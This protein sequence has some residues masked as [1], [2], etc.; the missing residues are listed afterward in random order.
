MSEREGAPLPK[1]TVS[2]AATT[3]HAPARERA[4]TTAAL[5]LRRRPAPLRELL[6]S[7]GVTLVAG[8]GVAHA[9]TGTACTEQRLR[10]E[11]SLAPQWLEPVVKL[12]EALG[13]ME[14]VDP[15]AQLRV[16]GAGEDVIVEVTLQDGRS[17]LRR[18]H[19]PRELPLTVEALVAVPPSPTPQPPRLV[20]APESHSAPPVQVAHVPEPRAAGPNR[21]VSLEAGANLVGRTE[22]S[23]IYLSIGL[24]AYAGVRRGPWLLAL[25]ARWDGFQTVIDER[26]D[27][28]VMT[29]AGG[30]FQVLR[31]FLHLREVAFEGGMTTWM[32][33]E[34]QAFE[35]GL[36]ER[37]GSIIDVRL[38]ALTRAVVGHGP[39]RW[40]A[41]LDS[42][43]SP[44][45]LQRELHVA[46][47]LPKLP[48]WS[49][50]V[51]GG[52]A[53]EGP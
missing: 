18:V 26:P 36:A 31:Q 42:E 27:D 29:T 4:C 30:G 3:L 34:T 2:F 52:V 32:L 45:R 41:S 35:R 16:V 20:A 14:D 48:A 10:I 46:P 28:F 49:V 5:S 22:G 38:G 15:S 19:T 47:G 44:A 23:P 8:Q 43:L 21:R 17:T 7:A 33:G 9:Q 6:F 50:G 53:W 13:A 12:C 25:T 24:T 1:E 40:T 39:L 51:G 37:A 11:G